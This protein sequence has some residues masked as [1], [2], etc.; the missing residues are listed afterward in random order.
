MDQGIIDERRIEN[1]VSKFWRILIVSVCMV[2]LLRWAT[3]FAQ[4]E[5][6]R[7]ENGKEGAVTFVH[8]AH[9][10]KKLKCND[11]HSQTCSQEEKGVKITEADHKGD[12]FCAACHSDGK[13]AFNMTDK[14]GCVKCHKK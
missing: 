9:L 13:K 11:C 3:A 8:K 2:C 7:H 6:A 1:V 10:A 14:A 5:W 4:K 12:K